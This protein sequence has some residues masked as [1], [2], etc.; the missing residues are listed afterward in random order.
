MEPIWYAR[1]D[2]NRQALV[3]K[4]SRYSNSRHGRIKMAP[5]LGLEPRFS[6]PITDSG[7]VDQTGYEGINFGGSGEIRT[8]ICRFKRPVLYR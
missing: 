7:F 6:A 2:S 8:H 4:T 3:S 1:S 5:P